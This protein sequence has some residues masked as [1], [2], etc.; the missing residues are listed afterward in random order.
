MP[1][2]GEGE[3]REGRKEDHDVNHPDRFEELLDRMLRCGLTVEFTPRH[4]GMFGCEI[5]SP[6]H[7]SAA[8]G[9]GY[10]PSAALEDV[11]NQIMVQGAERSEEKS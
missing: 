7:G 3:G 5:F 8:E 10:M 4:R 2:Q 1:S 6:D 9:R 11:S